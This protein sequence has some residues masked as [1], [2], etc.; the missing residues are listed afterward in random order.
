MKEIWKKGETGQVQCP[1]KF[2][3]TFERYI[4]DKFEIVTLEEQVWDNESMEMEIQ[5]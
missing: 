4:K 3:Q 5:K 2:P 1:Q